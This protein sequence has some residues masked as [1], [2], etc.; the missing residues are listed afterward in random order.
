MNGRLENMKNI[1]VISIQEQFQALFSNGISSKDY[2]AW[3]ALFNELD[4]KLFFSQEKNQSDCTTL[5][6]VSDRPVTAPVVNAV[7]ALACFY[8]LYYQDKDVALV[9][10][11]ELF[12][13]SDGEY[14]Y[15]NLLSDQ[16]VASDL[17]LFYWGDKNVTECKHTSSVTNLNLLLQH[18]KDKH[19][20][21][22]MK[23]LHAQ[24]KQ[25]YDLVLHVGANTKEVNSAV[26]LSSLVGRS[27]LFAEYGSTEVA[28]IKQFINISKKNDFEVLGSVM[29][30]VNHPFPKPLFD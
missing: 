22:Q 1:E 28:A 20:F 27:L 2:D 19:N 3:Y 26:I 14:I 4:A 8:A 9:I 6:A 29:Y 16:D 13:D 30:N 11:G 15:S 5:N 21:Q 12:D 25:D 23:Q 24:L 17:S 7:T 10:E 18:R